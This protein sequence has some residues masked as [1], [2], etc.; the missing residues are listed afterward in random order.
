MKM[1]AASWYSFLFLVLSCLLAHA[2]AS[3][4]V[5]TWGEIEKLYIDSLSGLRK[6]NTE[7]ALLL[8][9]ADSFVDIVNVARFDKVSEGV[10][11]K[12]KIKAFKS[13]KRSNTTDCELDFSA[14]V[15]FPSD[16]KVSCFVASSPRQKSP[17]AFWISVVSRLPNW[18]IVDRPENAMA[19]IVAQS[20]DSFSWVQSN[21]RSANTLVSVLQ[22]APLSKN[23][24]RHLLN[25]RR[26]VQLQK[27]KDYM[28]EFVCSWAS[29]GIRPPS[30][31]IIGEIVDC[32][33]AFS[34][35][36][37]MNEVNTPWFV[38]PYSKQTCQ[39]EKGSSM[40]GCTERPDPV[41]I[42]QGISPLR[43]RFGSCSA[44]MLKNE[45]GV[46]IE[47]SVE[48]P[49]LVHSRRIKLH[50]YLLFASTSPWVVLLHSGL[51]TLASVDTRTDTTASYSG[52]AAPDAKTL[53]RE[54]TNPF[55]QRRSNMAEHGS[56]SDLSIWTFSR[57]VRYLATYGLCES[58]PLCSGKIL[59]QVL[60]IAKVVTDASVKE[61]NRAQ[62]RFQLFEMS[63]WVT[64]SLQVYFDH[65]SED[66]SL[67][68]Y[69]F[70]LS[71]Q[72][73]QEHQYQSGSSNFLGADQV[74]ELA[75]TI[76]LDA[77]KIV[78]AFQANPL[79][80]KTVTNGTEWKT[81]KHELVD[82]VC[83]PNKNPFDPCS[84]QRASVL[85]SEVR[86][87]Q[88]MDSEGAESQRTDVQGTK[89]GVALPSNTAMSS[90][91]IKLDMERRL[92]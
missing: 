63:F 10:T 64:Q 20:G 38:K 60:E 88:P 19:V 72:R 70:A 84:L 86:I 22:N 47:K 26:Q 89:D 83:N 67:L 65:G 12:T 31:D 15:I 8:S 77:L 36:Q 73:K 41:H 33:G 58:E 74:G 92:S 35:H 56:V 27:A 66:L 5:R 46:I 2:V 45:L 3:T 80:T 79:K 61:V 50:S 49:L 57:L 4:S 13:R 91:S 40:F 54:T 25:S 29:L 34:M 85:S 62:G 82:N 75:Q 32:R 71:Q 81:V 6:I 43:K 11:S 59:D 76:G 23:T 21:L 9:N 14:Q 78:T 51:V 7:R 44:S 39:Q 16:T 69:A 53:Q 90:P 52:S 24:Q 68:Y 87:K 48:N 30:Y 42:I 17:K 28:Q 55:H 37:D 18:E 1:S